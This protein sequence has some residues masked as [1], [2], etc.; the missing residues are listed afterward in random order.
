MTWFSHKI[1][2]GSFIFTVTGSSVAALF[3]AVGSILPDALEGVPTARNYRRWRKNHR[4]MT[5][6]FVPYITVA[7][8]FLNFAYT[9]GVH[10]IDSQ[11]VSR[12]I[13]FDYLP[14]VC[15]VMAYLVAFIAFGACIHCLQDAL[16][17]TIPSLIPSVRIGIKL[18]PVK[19]LREFFFV[20]FFSIMLIVFK[21]K[22]G[23]LDWGSIF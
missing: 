17:G 10:N 14:F 1:L 21:L 4:K 16:C 12:L 6:W 18:F 7:I 11:T 2:T 20:G 9:H 5:H 23:Y 19:S 22:I 3:A 15:A 13:R 8:L